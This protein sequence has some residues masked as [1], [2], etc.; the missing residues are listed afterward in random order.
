[1]HEGASEDEEQSDPALGEG[2]R[3]DLGLPEAVEARCVTG[4][5]GGLGVDPLVEASS[6]LVQVLGDVAIRSSRAGRQESR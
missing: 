3:A 6:L 4:P 2:L 5:G 1:M